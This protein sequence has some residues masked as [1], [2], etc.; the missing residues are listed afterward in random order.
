MLTRR[1][2]YVPVTD[3]PHGRLGVLWFLAAI[4]ACALGAAAVGLLFTALAAVAALQTAIAWRRAGLAVDR[5]V[6][7]AGAAAVGLAAL[8]GIG[9]SGIALLGFVGVAV[10]VAL[11]ADGR[12]HAAVSRA[13][14]TVRCGAL[15]ALAAASVVFVAR[16]DLG[17]AIVLLV[18]ISAYEV[19][20]YL[21]GTGA[22]GIVEGPV[23]GI[24]AVVVFTFA[25]AVFQLGPFDARG[26]WVFG[27]L[28]AALAPLGSAV[29]SGLAPSAEQAPPALRRLDAWLLVAPA[30][31]WLLWGYLG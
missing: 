15:P 21:V 10:G 3:G 14:V 27:G 2:A 26:A 8:A 6:A 1:L 16:T 11:R 23:A 12:T 29:A 19:G 5:F 17:A 24:A 7:G 20:D 13:G 28:V 18:F 4:G 31:A 30:W 25:E 22:G 9:L